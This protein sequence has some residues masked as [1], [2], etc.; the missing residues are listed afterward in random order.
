MILIDKYDKAID[1]MN[2]DLTEL[3]DTYTYNFMSDS[4]FDE[5]HRDIRH[6][7]NRYLSL[8]PGLGNYINEIQQSVT[9]F[10]KRPNMGEFYVYFSINDEYHDLL[11][12]YD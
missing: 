2:N 9:D 12:E 1:D 3:A 5:I 10:S 8:H 6:I 7:V 11:I 4:T